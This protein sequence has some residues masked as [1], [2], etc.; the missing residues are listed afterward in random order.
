M[1]NEIGA[2]EIPFQ[3]II[4]DEKVNTIMSSALTRKQLDDYLKELTKY[5]EINYYESEK[6]NLT[7][8]DFFKEEFSFMLN[9]ENEQLVKL[10]PI[11]EDKTIK[12]CPETYSVGIVTSNEIKV[13][14][15]S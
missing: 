1:L 12:K 8:E 3:I 15:D 2:T 10:I 7:T 6:R 5:R 14:L 11:I 13:F 9:D 4:N